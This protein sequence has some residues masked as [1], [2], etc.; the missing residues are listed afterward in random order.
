MNFD[1]R[2]LNKEK[3]NFSSSLD[4]L[5]FNVKE[6]LNGRKE[7][8]KEI[9]ENINSFNLSCTNLLEELRKLEELR[10]MEEMRKH[11]KYSKYSEK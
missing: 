3:T 6:F 8:F 9:Q 7:K 4:G 10:R 5:V 11:S 2:K 1:N